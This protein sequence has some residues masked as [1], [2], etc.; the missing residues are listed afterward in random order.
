[1]LPNPFHEVSVTL[2]S[3]PDKDIT[4]KKANYKAISLINLG[5][6]INKVIEMADIN[7]KLKESYTIVK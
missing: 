4:Q 1:M 6:Q 5:A 2:I 3:K 7:N